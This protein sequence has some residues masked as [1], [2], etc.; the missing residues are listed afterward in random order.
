MDY[1]IGHAFQSANRHRSVGLYL[2]L[3]GGGPLAEI[4]RQ[5]DG[6]FEFEEPVMASTFEPS[7]T[8]RSRGDYQFRPWMCAKT[9][10]GRTAFRPYTLPNLER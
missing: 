2:P 8:R 9:S 3:A 6:T 7:R 4:T 10:P 1:F 5:V